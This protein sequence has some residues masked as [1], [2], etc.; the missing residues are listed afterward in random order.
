MD[1]III[2]A[3]LVIVVYIFLYVSQTMP[4]K[5]AFESEI[6]T[7]SSYPVHIDGAGSGDAYEKP[8]MRE[9]NADGMFEEDFVYQNEGGPNP[10]KDAINAAKRRFPFDWANLPPSSS[11]FQAQQS[12]FVKDPVSTASPFVKETFEA[13]EAEKILPQDID[14]ADQIEADALIG[15]RSKT[16]K[17]M[18]TVDERSVDELIQNIYGKKG[19]IAKVAKKAN[20]VYEV[21]E[22][23]EKNPKIVYE[24][25]VQ[26]SIQSNDLNPSMEPQDLVVRPMAVS[27]LD[28]GMKPWGNGMVTTSGRQPLSDYN[29]N[30]DKLMGPPVAMQSW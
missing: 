1:S 16:A 15:Y 12:L 14:A 9:T 11:L 10:S 29:P 18:K 22:T 8:Y 26:A 3:L 2:V 5:E 24:D 7:G 6:G 17:D 25:E 20:N 23:M 13:I 4:R 21:Y 30:F 28:A 27:D 19:L